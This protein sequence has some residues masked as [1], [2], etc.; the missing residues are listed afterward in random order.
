MAVETG[1]ATDHADLWD[2][3]QAF[4]TA[5]ADLVSAGE[6]W[7]VVWTDTDSSDVVLRGPGLSG[8]DNVYV[9]FHEN[10]DAVNDEYSISFRGMTGVTP[11]GTS[12]SQHVNVSPEV[13]M[14]TDSGPMTYWFVANGRRFI[15]VVKISTVFESAYCGF[16]LPYAQPSSYPYPMFIGGSAGQTTE[17]GVPTSWRSTSS[18]HTHFLSPEYDYSFG[19]AIR[20]PSAWMLDPLGQWLICS[21]KSQLGQVFMAPE[22]GGN[23]WNGYGVTTNMDTVRTRTRAC[24]GGDFALSLVHMMSRSPAEQTWG[25]FQGVYRMP[26]L[27]NAAEAL[28]T[29][30]GIDYLVVQNVFR[31][32]IGDYWALRLE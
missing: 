7:E 3:I 11:T 19:G 18:N 21:N 29:I 16:F 22:H 28:V 20:S 9:G 17:N 6:A 15:L 13:Q 27:G 8:T 26:G 24:F 4:L 31:T 32:T 1:T 5:N 30:D 2:K 14:F 10:V 25:V 23:S 12:F